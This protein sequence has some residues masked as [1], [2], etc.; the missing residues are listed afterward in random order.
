MSEKV[1][2]C[3]SVVVLILFGITACQPAKSDDEAIWRGQLTKA[4]YGSPNWYATIDQ[5]IKENPDN[6]WLPYHK[7]VPLF[8][9]GEYVEGMASLSKAVDLDPFMYANYRGAVKLTDLGDYEG[10]I[11]DFKTAIRL[12]NHVDI[13][14]PGSAYERMGIAYKQL[15]EYQ[16]AIDI[17][18][19]A[20]AKF[21]TDG[22]DLYLFM[23]RGMAKF[24]SGNAE[25]ALADFDVIINKW[26]KCPEAY[27]HKGLVYQQ[28]G[29]K[30]LACKQFKKAL[31][32][33]NYIHGNP[34]GAYIDQLYE[35]D[36]ERMFDLSCR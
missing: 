24:K 27:Y 1:L 16:K 33:K 4:G 34:G 14:I 31:L 35:A 23:Y 26:G 18:D 3:C 21:D 29:K 8:N 7:A 9:K 32:Y 19:E 22:V 6:A 30:D 13:I 17:F 5:L 12:R 36:I 2:M 25:G 20:V 10:A 11:E 15:G 28:Q